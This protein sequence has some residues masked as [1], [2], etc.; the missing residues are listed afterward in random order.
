[1]KEGKVIGLHSETSRDYSLYCS[2][3][4]PRQLPSESGAY[5]L[6]LRNWERKSVVVGKLGTMTV[7]VGFYL[8]VGSA[9]GPGGLQA[10]ISH[11]LKPSLKPFWHID[12]LRR[13]TTPVFVW[14]QVHSFVQ[15]HSWAKLLRQEH[16]IDIAVRRFGSSDCNCKS[17]LFFS[18]TQPDLNNLKT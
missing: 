13:V 3:Q 1:M 5:V 8:Y 15:E 18:D 2:G 17:H 16:G 6:V 7:R 14:F 10:R 4:A 12:Y 9:F 11:H